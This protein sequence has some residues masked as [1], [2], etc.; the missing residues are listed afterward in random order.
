MEKRPQAEQG[1][2]L[3]ASA[4]LL[5]F[6]PRKERLTNCR[7]LG[8][9]MRAAALAELLLSGNLADESGKA[10]AVT[11]PA[12]PGPLQAAVWEQI[13]TSKPRTW[14]RW[15]DWDRTQAYRLIRDELATA[16]LV[17]I[18]HHRFLMFRYERVKP[19]RGYLSRRL[20]ERVGRAIRG[21]QPVNRVDEDVRALAALAAAV[22]LKTVMS[23]RERHAHKGRLDELAGPVR[24]VTTALRKSV[25]AANAAAAAG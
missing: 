13:T 17:Q 6:D 15:V 5:A 3:P 11:P 23:G 7:D 16:R 9:L 24:P 4:F 19:R 14:R 12:D 10:R 21:G 22:R 2:S 18:E 1:E 8:R 20:A 25:D